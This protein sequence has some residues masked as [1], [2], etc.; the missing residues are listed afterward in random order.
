MDNQRRGYLAYLLRLWQ[1]GD[2]QSP[3]WRVSLEDPRSG[4]RLGFVDLESAFV[5]LKEQIHKQEVTSKVINPNP[6]KDGQ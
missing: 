3:A 4:Q 5:F 6:W 2:S 1:T